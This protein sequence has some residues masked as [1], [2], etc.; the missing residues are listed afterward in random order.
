MGQSLN[1]SDRISQQS[2]VS[3]DVILTGIVFIV[4]IIVSLEAIVS[5]GTGDL[6]FLRKHGD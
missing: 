4:I 3:I 6:Y 2:L 5:D 1:V